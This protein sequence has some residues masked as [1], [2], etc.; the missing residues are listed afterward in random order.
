MTSMRKIYY[1]CR[2]Y[3][4][5]SVLLIPCNTITA[6]N[7]SVFRAIYE[8]D[9]S[10]QFDVTLSHSDTISLSGIGGIYS[11]SIDAT[12]FQPKEGCF[13]RIVLEDKDG[14]NYLVVES[15]WCRN[16]T[17]I[18]NLTEYC[19]ETA[20]LDGIVPLRL[21]CYLTDG[22]SIDITGFHVSNQI[23][24][25]DANFIVRN[26]KEI[27]RKQVLNIV[28]RINANNR[29]HHKLWK[30][31]LTGLSIRP[32]EEKMAI[33]GCPIDGKTYGI[34]YY[35]SGIIDIGASLQSSLGQ[36]TSSPYVDYFDW[37]DQHGKNWITP[38]KDQGGSGYC[39]AFSAIS[40]TEALVNLYLNNLIS[41]DL[42]E[43][44]A[45]SCNSYTLNSS[46]NFYSDG[47][48]IKY[49]LFYIRDVGVC[50]EDSYPFV[51]DSLA[52]FCHSD[53]VIPHDIVTI[54][55]ISSD[56][57]FP[58]QS[59]EERIK[60]ALIKYGPLSS[61]I[62]TTAGPNHAMALI[63][64][65]IIKE[66]DIVQ[67]IWNYSGINTGLTDTIHVTHDNPLIG[68][69]FWIF[70]NSYLNGGSVNQPYM[71]VTMDLSSSINNTYALFNPQLRRRASDGNYELVNDVVCE[72]SDGD[73]F[74]FWGLGPKPSHCPA[75]APD[76]SDGDDSDR[77]KGH[78]NEYGFCEELS[79]EC[80]MYQYIANDTTLVSP[81]NRTNYLGVL[82]GA[83]VTLQAQ[84]VFA[85]GTQLLLDNGATLI[86]NGVT[87]SG[88]YLRPYPGSKIFLNN[89]AKIQK[90]FEVPL[91]VELIINRGSIE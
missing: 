4:L 48:P 46:E 51:D 18:V 71:L 53:L 78:M 45:A 23:P 9:K 13:T 73:G 86:I 42:S 32:H 2:W 15:D 67:R 76:E 65:G 40:C 68:R 29:K 25:R 8:P 26:K 56:L 28:D 44:E 38:V 19:E 37:R 66:G 84:Q 16:D 30:A 1:L 80:P 72:D 83:T 35:S 79:L 6:Q 70:K 61:G 21:K 20:I 58:L 64:Y 34:E 63:G 54:S 88:S 47:M 12:I 85:N 41:L 7:S 39:S 74:Y 36:R 89:G 10:L 27:R 52:R 24:T 55:G 43:Q 5:I 69:N 91:G 57:K 33:L 75:W 60:D 90:P 50:D 59:N 3:T 14:H 87:I 49:P 17:T 31:G 82:R 81:E 77:S 22:A 62:Y 11:F